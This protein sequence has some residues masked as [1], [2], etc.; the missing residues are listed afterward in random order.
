MAT[1]LILKNKKLVEEDEP[2]SSLSILGGSSSN[3]VLLHSQTGGGLAIT[4]QSRM[5][6]SSKTG[7]LP[8]TNSNLFLGLSAHS[9][10]S[11]T[12]YR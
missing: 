11:I 10:Y 12:T 2:S 3:I 6:S 4:S 8:M 9:N 1:S 5:Y 7:G